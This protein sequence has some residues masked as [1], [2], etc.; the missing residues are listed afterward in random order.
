[1]PPRPVDL[2]DARLLHELQRNN[3]ASVGHLC[4]TV[5]LT[6][7]TCQRRLK[8]LRESGLIQGEVAL[9]D[10]RVTARPLTVVI[11]L[12]LD[13]IGGERRIA[14]ERKLAVQAE[15]SMVWAVSGEADFVCIGHFRDI[16]H[17]RDFM[18]R[19]LIGSELVRRQTTFVGIER[20]RFELALEFAVAP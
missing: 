11:E 15:F 8:K 17:Y 2:I 14:F 6:L 13:Q 10:P 12:A 5:G 4:E 16:E 1:M 20:L 18:L 19:E 7:A 9:V 3:R